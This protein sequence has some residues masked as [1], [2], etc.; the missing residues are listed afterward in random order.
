M[1][2]KDSS[3]PDSLRLHPGQPHLTPEQEAEVKRFAEAYIQAQLS[4]E[5]VDESAA[6]AL[7]RQAYQVAGL[8]AP[9]RIN[10][11]DGPLQLAASIETS[12]DDTGED[13]SS[14]YSLRRSVEV[15]IWRAITA[16]AAPAVL[17]DIEAYV[18]HDVAFRVW[19]SIGRRIEDNLAVSVG[20]T[21]KASVMAYHEAS[22]LALFHFYATYLAPNELEASAHFNAL[23]SGYWLG[24]KDAVIVR[25]PKVLARDAAGRL[26]SAT[27]KCVE[28]HDGWGFYAL[29]GVQVPAKVILAPEQLTRD[30]FLNEPDMEVSHII[31]E[32]MGSRF[33][34][35]LGGRVIESGPRGTLYEVR[36]PGD[37]PE[38][39]A[40]Y[41]QVQ[42]FSGR[43]QYFFRVP[44]TIQTAADA[45]H[46]SF[47][48]L[49]AIP[50]DET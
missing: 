27:G 39:M 42:D 11:V 26:H 5:P 22:W 21:T 25:R 43:S 2:K 50:V 32:R 44:P 9:R 46:W 12:A 20:R 48:L 40:R 17:S 28:Y 33:V 23:V 47:D 15:S 36:L 16:S 35:E 6:E 3:I 10:W 24:P 45:V 30:D 38:Q 4:T 1:Q 19:N 18:G 37:D 13:A 7:L 8:A 49:I 29:H 34:P 31:Q 41:I 14:G